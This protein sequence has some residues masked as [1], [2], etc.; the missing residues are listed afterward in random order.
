MQQH[1]AGFHVM[2]YHVAGFHVMQQHVTGFL[3]YLFF[4][5]N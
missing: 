4:L 5:I 2:Q 1:V 3:F